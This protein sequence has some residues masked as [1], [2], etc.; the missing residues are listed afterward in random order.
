MKSSFKTKNV[1][2][3]SVTYVLISRGEWTDL[4]RR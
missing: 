3:T 2:M 1:F 4:K